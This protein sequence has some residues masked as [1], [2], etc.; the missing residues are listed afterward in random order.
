[1]SVSSDSRFSV[2]RMPIGRVV[3]QAFQLVF[4][5]LPVLLLLV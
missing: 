1:M 2:C 5:L 4:F 3:E